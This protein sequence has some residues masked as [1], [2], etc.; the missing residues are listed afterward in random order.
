MAVETT[1][2]SE[3]L[4]CPSCVAKIERGLKRLSGVE[5]VHV[6][7]GSGRIDVRHRPDVSSDELAAALARLGYEAH[8]AAF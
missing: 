2:R 6:A 4:T 1:L 8:E 5:A 3:S 7:F